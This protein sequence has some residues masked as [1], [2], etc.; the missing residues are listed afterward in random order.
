MRICHLRQSDFKCGIEQAYLDGKINW[1]NRHA[2]CLFA[3]AKYDIWGE[4]TTGGMLQSHLCNFGQTGRAG[5][6]V[7]K[8]PLIHKFLAGWYN[9]LE[10]LVEGD[11]SA[12]GSRFYLFSCSLSRP[13]L[14]VKVGEA[15]YVP[16]KK[17]ISG[18]VIQPDNY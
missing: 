12:V 18:G 14:C 16:N 8:K 2:I 17:P 4:I 3:S 1:R 5:I 11:E 15:L 10:T 7:L 6:S 9:E 13:L